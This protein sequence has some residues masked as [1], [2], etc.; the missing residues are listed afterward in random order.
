MF[1]CHHCDNRACVRPDH[2]FLGTLQDNNADM[3]QKHRHAWGAKS[4][5]AKLTPA[6]VEDVRA[7]YI[8]ELGWRPFAAKYGISRQSVY[9]I[10]R[11]ETYVPE[12][13]VA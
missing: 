5:F 4:G 8:P 3:R 2:L 10:V 11:R 1:V 7:N 12:R 6:Q 13:E 9:R